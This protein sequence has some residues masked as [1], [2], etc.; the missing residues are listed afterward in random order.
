VGDAPR[1][2]IDR[3]FVQLSLTIGS[4]RK[5]ERERAA[6]FQ[7]KDLGEIL[8]HAA[9]YP[10]LV[11]LGRPGAGKSTLLR[12]L[13]MDQCMEAIRKDSDI[14]SV[15]A[16]LN[17]VPAGMP[18]PMEWLTERWKSEYPRLNPPLET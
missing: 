18:D 7:S 6:Q 8:R 11:L 15:F 5:D 10:A 1:Y 17:S 12:R 9:D 16:P 4:D 3:Q 2:A 14:I 13:Q